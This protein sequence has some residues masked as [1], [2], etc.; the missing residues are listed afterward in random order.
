M[1]RLRDGFRRTAL[2]CL[3][4]LL[5]ATGFA[6][7]TRTE[8]TLQLDDP[9][10]RRAATIED[11]AWLAGT[12]EGEAFGGTFEE[13]WTEPS[14]GTMV[15]SYKLMHGEEITLYEI[16]LIAEEAGS[17]VLKVKHFGPE[18][19]A[20]EEKKEHL[21]FPLVKLTDDAIYFQGFTLRRIDEDRVQAFIVRTSGDQVSDAELTYRRVKV[22][23]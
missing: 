21:S 18:F 2:S 9:D 17:L 12:W 16:E 23:R 19:A 11:V 13:V 15:G 6:Q 14:L 1:T 8:N 4:V 22:H 20:W 7:S 3:F 5:P 10:E